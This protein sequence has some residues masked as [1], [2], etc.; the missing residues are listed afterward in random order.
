MPLYDWDSTAG[1]QGYIASSP[2]RTVTPTLKIKN[3]V[4]NEVITLTALA[5]GDVYIP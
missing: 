1:A 5:D 2:A 3:G 4:G